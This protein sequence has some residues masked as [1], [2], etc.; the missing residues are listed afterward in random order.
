[1]LPLF[2]SM[3]PS[4][5]AVVSLT[6]HVRSWMV[7]VFRPS[8]NTLDDLVLVQSRGVRVVNTGIGPHRGQPIW[9]HT[10]VASARLSGTAWL[11]SCRLAVSFRLAPTPLT[12]TLPGSDRN[13]SGQQVHVVTP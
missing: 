10:I 11:R 2:P 3:R 6:V 12:R 5:R 9:D 7:E 4:L 8:P 13:P 1:M